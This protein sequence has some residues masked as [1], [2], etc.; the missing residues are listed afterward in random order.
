VGVRAGGRGGSNGVGEGIEDVGVGVGEG[1]HGQA[2]DGGVGHGGLHVG[3]GVGS[4]VGCSVGVA[5][6]ECGSIGE[7]DV[8]T[9]PETEGGMHDVTNADV[10]SKIRAARP[11]IANLKLG[12]GLISLPPSPARPDDDLP[13]ACP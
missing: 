5:G 8:T 7:A 4:G 10:A 3:V 1:S 13:R 2:S 12:S 9:A 11:E 6:G